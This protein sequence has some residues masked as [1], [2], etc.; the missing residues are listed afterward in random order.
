MVMVMKSIFKT[1]EYS[2]EHNGLHH[3]EIEIVITE[4]KMALVRKVTKNPLTTLKK[5][6]QSSTEMEEPAGRTAILHQSNL[7]GRL[8]RQKLLLS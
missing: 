2:L 3:C 5:I 6:Q 4:T 1:F 7:Y 8:T